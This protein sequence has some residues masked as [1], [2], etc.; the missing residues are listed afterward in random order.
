MLLLSIENTSFRKYLPHPFIIEPEN[1]KKT[2][3]EQGDNFS[4][5]LILIGRAIEYLPYFIYSF[6]ILGNLGIGKGRGKYFLKEVFSMDNNSNPKLIYDG[7]HQVLTNKYYVL[8]G[9]DLLN[10]YELNNE[11]ISLNFITPTRIKYD[12]KLIDNLE[13]HVLI[14]NLLRRLSLIIY[15]HCDYELNIDYK[16]LIEESKNVEIF[17]SNL[18]WY[19]LE[20]YSNRQNTRMKMGGFIGKITYKGDLTPYIPLIE[21]GEHIHVGKGVSFGLGKYEIIK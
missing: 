5:D 18:R 7:E 20:R 10:D 3:Y 6:K 11:T 9:E 15:R 21:I 16:N 8:T 14:R 19:D 17:D 4:F 1:D 2:I 13:F 12:R